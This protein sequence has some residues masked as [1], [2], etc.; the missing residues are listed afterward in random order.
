MEQPAIKAQSSPNADSAARY[1]VR[2]SEEERKKWGERAVALGFS[3][4]L[5]TTDRVTDI[6]PWYKFVEQEMRD[7]GLWEPPPPEPEKEKKAGKVIQLPL[8]PEP[9][10][11]VPNDILRS[12]LFASIQGSRRYI[13]NEVIAAVDGVTITFKGEQLD[14]S[15]LDVWEQATHLARSQPLGHICHF[16]ANAFLKDI[17]RDN[18]RAQYKWLDE[19]IKRLIACAVEIRNGSRVFTGSLLSS[20]CRDEETGVYQLTLDPKTMK[21]YSPNNWSSVEWAQRQAMIGKPLALWLH[22]FFS[23]HAAPLPYK[24]ETLRKLCGSTD[25]TLRSYR[26][27]LRKALDDLKASAAIVAWSIDPTTDLVTVDR[28]AALTDSQRRHLAK[29][30]R[31]RKPKV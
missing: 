18:G 9:V 31:R 27:K 11:A 4:K 17:G 8:W 26:Q 21:L 23:S 14:Q 25:K 24:V 10:R 5:K 3:D 2:A 15:D 6:L 22:G 13:K 12:A 28:G 1:L 19:S 20:C 29:P 30:A 16:R 7:Q